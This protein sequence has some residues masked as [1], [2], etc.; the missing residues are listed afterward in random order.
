MSSHFPHN[1]ICAVDKATSAYT[2]ALHFKQ[3]YSCAPSAAAQRTNSTITSVT[4]SWCPSIPSSSPGIDPDHPRAH[5]RRRFIDLPLAND[6]RPSF[7]RG[8]N[9]RGPQVLLVLGLRR[10][11]FHVERPVVLR[12]RLPQLQ[13]LGGQPAHRFETDV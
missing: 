2:V 3:W 1:G 5:G 12:R 4:G 13:Q 6:V 11:P 9:E 10:V 7:L 8:V